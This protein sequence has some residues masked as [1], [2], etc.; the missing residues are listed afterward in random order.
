SRRSPSTP[1]LQPD[2]PLAS[3]VPI[4]FCSSVHRRI[5][6]PPCCFWPSRRAS[7]FLLAVPSS[8]C[9]RLPSLLLAVFE[10][11]LSAGSEVPVP[12]CT[13]EGIGRLASLVGKPISKFVRNGTSVKVCVLMDTEAERPESIRVAV[14]RVQCEVEVVYSNSRVYKE[15]KE[16]PVLVGKPV[17]KAVY[18][19]K[20]VVPVV[21]DEIITEFSKSNSVWIGGKAIS[22]TQIENVESAQLGNDVANSGTSKKDTGGLEGSKDPSSSEEVG[23]DSSGSSTSSE[24]GNTHQKT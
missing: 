22:A 20:S 13:H 9:S 10:A 17:N 12:L 4:T 11:A 1:R 16:K 24:D 5:V 18:V 19:A 23:A 2:W 3:A 8:C 15:T 14:A 7:L 21:E 6:V